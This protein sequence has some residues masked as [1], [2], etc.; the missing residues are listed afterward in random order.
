VWTQLHQTRPVHR[1]IIAALHLCFKIWISC[2]IFKCGWLKVEW[3]FKRRQISHFFDPSPVKIR[4]GVT[5]SLYQLLKLYQRPNLRN[6]FDG[7]P[8]CGCWARWI[9]TKERKR[10]K[11]MGKTKAFPTNVG[12]PKSNSLLTSKL[13]RKRKAF[14]WHLTQGCPM[15]IHHALHISVHS[16]SELACV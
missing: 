11:F 12:Q 14:F 2:C 6:T 16:E 13:K 3:S 1:A 8:L 15:P 5:R 7:H 10:T 4:G 9:D